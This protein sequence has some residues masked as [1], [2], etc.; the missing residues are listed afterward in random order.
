MIFF[1][2]AAR[3]HALDSDSAVINDGK[4]ERNLS[5][6]FCQKPLKPISRGTLK[7]KNDI[8]Q[9]GADLLTHAI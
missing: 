8:S 5:T 4:T 3:F 6:H 1:Y 2:F 9:K 7:P